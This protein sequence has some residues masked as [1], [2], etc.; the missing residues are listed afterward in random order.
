[1]SDQTLVFYNEV[2]KVW[3]E[4]TRNS[5]QTPLQFQLEV[6]KKLLNI[7]QPGDYYYFIFNV[8]NAEFEFISSQINSILGYD[9]S[10]LKA[11]DFL[12]RIHAEDQ[13]YFIAFEKQLVIF[14]QA[15]PVEKIMKYKVQYD[16]RVKDSKGDYR[17]ILH[18]LAIIEHDDDKNVIRSLGI[19]T[20]ITHLKVSGLPRLSFIGLEEEPSYYDVAID[21]PAL[22]PSKAPF[23]R[24]EKQILGFVLSG[25]SSQ[26]IATLLHISKHTVNTHR[27]KILSKS[28]CSSW[29]EMRV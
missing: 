7:F 21:Q 20:D 10:T 11:A 13:P 18:Q 8:R 25:K 12:N 6:H 26:E 2:R 19:H 15:L 5:A 1:M 27:K 29:L 23:T 22:F 16:F 4:V 3:E 24:R 14:F 28:G 9:V 17:R